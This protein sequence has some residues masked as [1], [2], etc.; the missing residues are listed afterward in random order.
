MK[1][2]SQESCVPGRPCTFTLSLR[3]TEGKGE[4]ERERK[5]GRNREKQ[6]ERERVSPEEIG[7]RKESK[8]SQVSIH[9]VMFYD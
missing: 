6:R 1:S 7:R 5:G 8:N 4:G 2:R 3:E 9:I